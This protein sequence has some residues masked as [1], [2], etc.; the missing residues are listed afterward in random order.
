M[1]GLLR[2]SAAAQRVIALD[3]G[4]RLAGQTQRL[5]RIHGLRS[6]GFAV[7]QPMQQVQDM[8]FCRRAIAQS[9]LDG[10]QHGLFVVLERG[11]Y[12]LSVLRKTCPQPDISV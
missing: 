10:A 8:G 2:S 12:R 11:K 3:I 7:D 6:R 5:W 4:A 1:A 9:Q